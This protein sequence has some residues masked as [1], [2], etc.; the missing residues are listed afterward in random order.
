MMKT[1]TSTELQK[2]TR[3]VIDW[4]R[5]R[6]ETVVIETYG[7]PMAAILSYDEYQAYQQYKQARATRFTQLREAAAANAAANTLSE[8][9]ALA[10]VDAE[11]QAL[12]R[13]QSQDEDITG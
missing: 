9:E 7:K 12:Y 4:A 8:A 3:E 6:R 13:E 5:T 10:L 1:V 11:R 2:N